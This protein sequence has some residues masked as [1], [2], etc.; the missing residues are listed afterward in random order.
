[1]NT[2]LLAVESD[3]LT[4]RQRA[5]L[6]TLAPE[7]DL[8]VT[9]DRAE[10]EAV[11]DEIEIAAGL[12]PPEIIVG[13]PNLRWFQQFG[14]GA[15]WLLRHPEAVE[16]PF[17]LTNASG[18]HSIPIGEHIF[19]LLLTFARRLH[20][21]WAAQQRGEWAAP[22]GET[23][24]ELAGKT[25]LLIGVGAI[26][27]RTAQLAQA[28]G[29][30]VIG[31]RRDPTEAAAGVD[32]LHGPAQLDALL[33]EADVVVVTAPLTEE[34]RHMIDAQALRRMKPTAYL[35][36]IGRGGMLDERALVRALREGEIAAAGLDVFETEPLPPD[37][38]L[39]ELDN[40]LITPHY[41]GS[42]PHY[43][44]RFMD[45]FLDNLRRFREG[46][47]LRNLVDKELGY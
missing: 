2:I 15:D 3:W 25:M 16:Q 46:E 43:V 5:T 29:M 4:E 21:A 44:E 13:A 19:A 27:E 41:A 37:S 14:A 40:V 23:L 26:G 11:L 36:N 28:F 9:R 17:V 8:V 24:F 20:E 38:P 47:P 45:I 35:I 34:T 31:V 12:V 32:V 18:I 42:T 1:M 10:M 6:E 33:P 22:R 7:A 39:W 30:R